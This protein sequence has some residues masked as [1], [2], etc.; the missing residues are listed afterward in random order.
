[1]GFITENE[2]LRHD[3][4]FYLPTEILCGRGKV[5]KLGVELQIEPDLADRQRVVLV[6]D[7]GVAAAG[8]VDEVLAG[9]ADS[10][11]DV[12]TVFDA[13]PPD[14]DVTTVYHLS[15]VIRREHAQLIIALGGGS[16][17]DTAKAGSLIATHGGEIRDYVGGFMVP[18]P[19]LPL[20]A[21]PTTTGTGSEVS[22]GA[23]VK[24]QEA[25]TKITITSPFLY[26][27]LAI[28]DPEMVKTLPAR[29]VA[30]TGMDALTHAI[31]AYVSSDHDP[32]SEA[33]A[34]R[35]TEMIFDNLEAAVNESDHVEA[36]ARLQLAATMAAMAFNSAGLGAVHAINHTVG[37]M[38]GIHHG[39]GNAV[40]LPTVME[41]NR[42]ACPA[43]FA[44]LARAMGVDRMDL[45][46]EELGRWAIERVRQLRRALGIPQC[47][48]D[49]GV[50]TDEAT[51][52][53]IAEGAMNDMLLAF[54]P[55]KM[56]VDE[57]KALVARVVR[58]AES[59]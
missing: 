4:A 49:L 41:Y 1:M 44:A 3:L 45:S 28:L 5:R 55:R 54:N 12:I 27:R 33:L 6:T 17:M 16:V 40:A 19:C 43:R 34:F 38:F 35:A 14:S 22:L 9:L 24:D 7:K 52:S 2:P 58:G 56:S 31:E 15:E 37:A 48:R 13:V 29:L 53:A 30:W 46:Q 59:E 23:V 8:L 11:Y 57:M 50:P 42:P 26:P 25:R 39:L 20:I 47:Y 32:I 36:R 10:S 21:I 51:I 18:G